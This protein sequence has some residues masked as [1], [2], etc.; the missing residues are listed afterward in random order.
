MIKYLD[1]LRDWQKTTVAIVYDL[2]MAGLA[3]Y[4]AMGLRYSSFNIPTMSAARLLELSAIMATIQSIIFLQNSFYKGLWRYSS[5]NDLLR[6]IRGSM[7]ATLGSFAILFFL[8]RL[9]NIPRSVL[10]ID[11]LLLV[12]LLGGGRFAYRIFRDYNVIKKNNTEMRNILIVGAGV[13]GEQFLRNIRSNPQLNLRVVAFVDDDS[14]LH[15]KQIHQVPVAGDIEKIPTVCEKYGVHKIFV[16]IPNIAS[17]RLRSIINLCREVHAP[18]KILPRVSDML[19]G[20]IDVTSFKSV[21]LEDLVGRKSINLDSTSIE[22]MIRDKVILVTGAGGSIGSELCNQIAKFGP[23]E[24]V[25]FEISEFNL[26]SLEQNLLEK[27][28][29]LNL[30][31]IIGDVRDEI[32]VGQ[33]FLQKSPQVVLHAAAYKHVPIME[34][35]PI[36]AVITNIKGTKILVEA[37]IKYKVS[38]FVMVSTDK[39]VNPTNIMGATKRAAEIICQFNQAQSTFTKFMTV[40]FG[41]V[42]GS[43]GS[44]IP[45]F[46]KQIQKGG[47]VT[48][49]HPEINRFFMSIPEA[50]QLI[51]Q[52][53][54]IGR[55]GELFVLDMGSPIKILDLARQLISLNGLE[56]GKDI[57]IEFTG[58]RPGEKLYEEVLFETEGNLPT[59][60]PMVRMAKARN[61][62]QST[63]DLVIK[64]INASQDENQNLTF[65][66]IREKL[67]KI[68]PE[69]SST[70]STGTLYL[71]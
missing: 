21:D 8:T 4:L 23:K 49:T 19:S 9:E 3:F 25:V 27:F 57:K 60:H 69:Y 51:L 40:R 65:N 48:I 50:S 63:I 6:V 29:N 11:W 43:S 55:G 16:A 64:L 68:V 20:K 35:N 28:P 38:R 45:L 34:R 13:A 52:A 42:M 7:L 62:E 67:M 61:V 71:F 18:I 14:N 15:N 2:F 1:N 46:Q 22:T 41:N 47:P 66:E 37:A 30:T 32:L 17:E 70:G 10:V 24:L 26:Y 39:A 12:I 54:A 53:G 31:P 5:T 56:E 36:Q 59:S 33:L 44:V 58:L